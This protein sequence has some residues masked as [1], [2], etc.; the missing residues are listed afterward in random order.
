MKEL[1]REKSSICQHKS[2]FDLLFPWG[3][4]WD[5]KMLQGFLLCL[6]YGSD[7]LIIKIWGRMV[8]SHIYQRQYGQALGN[9]S[10]EVIQHEACWFHT[11][12]FI[13]NAP[14]L[15]SETHVSLAL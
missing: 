15:S 6:N 7:H 3:L 1:K 4:H 14:C 11:F 12:N 8:L 13:K 5:K 10:F 2:A 9:F